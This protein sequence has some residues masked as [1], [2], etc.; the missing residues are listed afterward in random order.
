MLSSCGVVVIQSSS[1]CCKALLIG[2]SSP[3][4]SA[5]PSLLSPSSSTSVL[6]PALPFSA[7]PAPDSPSPCSSSSLL[8][9]SSPLSV[10]LSLAHS[11][12]SSKAHRLSTLSPRVCNSRQLSRISPVSGFE[13][14]IAIPNGEEFRMMT[15]RGSLTHNCIGL[16]T[17]AER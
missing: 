9:D 14:S 8:V 15:A 12:Q 13:L 10:L 1:R 2:E 4:L 5:L 16:S 17:K 3:S 11:L 6:F 7:S